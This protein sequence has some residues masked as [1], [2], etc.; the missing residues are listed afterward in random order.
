MKLSTRLCP[1]LTKRAE[2]EAGGTWLGTTIL[3]KSL[4]LSVGSECYNYVQH[5]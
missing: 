3:L 4:K 1:E 5:G 2:V